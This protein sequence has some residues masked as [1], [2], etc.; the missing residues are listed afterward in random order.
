MAFEPG[1]LAI[2]PDDA[3]T[4]IDDADGLV[5]SFQQRSLLDM[6][7]DKGAELARADGLTAAVADAVERFSHR[8]S[9]CVGSREDVVGRIIARIRSRRHCRRRKTRTF[10]VGPV[11]DA[12][13][14]F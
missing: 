3:L 5:F 6:Q 12:D 1:D 13:W 10:L 9:R 14:C 2:V 11:D 4:A 8:D 7:F